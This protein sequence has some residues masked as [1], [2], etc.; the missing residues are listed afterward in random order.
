VCLIS[1]YKNPRHINVILGWVPIPLSNDRIKHCIEELF[2]QAISIMEKKHKDG[3][4]SGIRIVT[5]IKADLD[6]N[7][8]PS[9]I[10][11]DGFELYVT[12]QGQEITC[13]YCGEVGHMQVNCEKRKAEFPELGQNMRNNSFSK[14]QQVDKSKNTVLCSSH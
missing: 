13:K 1:D 6:T 8:S 9:Y 3:L 12:Y 10:N 2:G 4:Q 5:V 7:P 11:V 14:A